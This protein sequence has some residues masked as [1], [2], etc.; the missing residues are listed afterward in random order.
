MG[1]VKDKILEEHQLNKFSQ[2]VAVGCN[3]RLTFFALK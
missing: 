3:V 1:A 2:T